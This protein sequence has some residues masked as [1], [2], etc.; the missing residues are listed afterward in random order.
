MTMHYLIFYVVCANC[1]LPPF[2]S[3]TSEILHHDNRADSCLLMR[4]PREMRIIFQTY[5]M[6]TEQ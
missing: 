2:G 4:D 3:E 5:L 1:Q 6:S